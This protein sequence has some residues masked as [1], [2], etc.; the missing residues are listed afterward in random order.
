M[1]VSSRVL[2]RKLLIRRLSQ[3][4]RKLHIHKSTGLDE[5]PLTVQQRLANVM[6]MTET[7]KGRATTHRHLHWLEKG[8]RENLPKFN[9]SKCKPCNWHGLT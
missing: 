3:G 8:A 9:K 1:S 4:C 2:R 5:L 6:A 7:L